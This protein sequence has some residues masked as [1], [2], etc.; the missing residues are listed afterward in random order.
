MT[1]GLSNNIDRE[2]TLV[3]FGV[4]ELQC[5]L[6]IDDVDEIKRV[7]TI[8]RV[9]RAPPYVSGVVNIR[10]QIVTVIDLRYQLSIENDD[11]MQQHKMVIVR[12]GSEQIGL[13]VDSIEDTIII[14][15]STISTPP[16]NLDEALRKYI[17]Y[18]C[19]TADTLIAILDKSALID[20]NQ[21]SDSNLQE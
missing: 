11:P 8:T 1:T 2:V 18:V 17:K 21:S 10:G 4:G 15:E 20:K 6:P 7:F 13:L 14:P 19:K 5:G 12:K 16:P 3:T 9:H